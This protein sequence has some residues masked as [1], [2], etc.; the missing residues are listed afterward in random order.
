MTTT[1]AM[2]MNRGDIRRTT[3]SLAKEP[4]MVR[5]GVVVLVATVA[6]SN[7]SGKQV[8]DAAEQS[9][10]E[11]RGAGELVRGDPQYHR[12]VDGAV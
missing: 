3:S 5:L 9:S 11:A 2:R 10:D 12:A 4:V 1:V 8:P 6:C 7:G